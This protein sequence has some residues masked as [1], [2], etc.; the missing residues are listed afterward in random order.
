MHINASLH[1]HICP[2]L[3]IF[4]YLLAFLW[5]IMKRECNNNQVNS[6][7]VSLKEHSSD[8]SRLL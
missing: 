8:T 2:L 3:I 4:F 1:R 6:P 5:L 7:L